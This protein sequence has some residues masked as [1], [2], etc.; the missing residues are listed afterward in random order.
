MISVKNLLRVTTIFTA[1]AVVTVSLVT[2]NSSEAKAADG[3]QFDA[4]NII[5]D[6]LFYDGQAMS[7][8]EVQNFLN[9]MVSTCRS[10]YTCLKDYRQD[11]STKLAESG[12]CTQY[13]GRTN[14][15]A[16]DIIYRVG[17]ACGISQKV[18]IVLLQKEQ[19]LITDTWPTS[20]QYRKATGYACPDTAACDATF[21]GFFNQVYMAALQYKR[22]KANPSGY[23]FI[24]G[25][26][27]NI[28]YNPNGAC[29]SS[30]VFI[31]NAATAGLYDYTPYQPNSA[32][33]ANLY[34]TGDGCSAYGNRN[35][36]RIYTDWFGST[37]ASS[38][39]RTV[40][41]GTVYLMGDG[42][43]YPILDQAT[44][45]AYSALGP[46]SYVSQTYL[47][48]YPTGRPANRIIR[49][50]SGS[51][52][53]T[54]AGIK[55]PFYSC[56][57]VVDYGGACATN[58]YI[59]LTGTQISKFY[60]GPP[61][62]PFIST[63]SG[64]RYYI[65]GGQAREI[66]DDASLAAAGLAGSANYLTDSAIVGLSGGYPIIRDSVV[67]FSRSGNGYLLANSRKYSLT[68]ADAF[69]LRISSAA[70]NGRLS[71]SSL[72]FVQ[73]GGAFSGSVSNSQTIYLASDSGLVASSTPSTVSGANP[74]P[75]SGAFLQAVSISATSLSVGSFV[76]SP[77]S[78]TV[79][80]IMQNDIRPIGAWDSLVAL[81]PP[82]Q[83]IRIYTI[84]DSSIAQM[85][86]GFV[87]LTSGQLYRDAANATVYLINGTTSK[88]AFSSFAF[89]AALGSTTFSYTEPDRLAAYPT[90]S[91]LLTYGV[92]CGTNSYVSAGGQLHEVSTS[93]MPLFPFTYVQLDYFSCLQLS[94]GTPATSFIRD[95]SGSLYQLDSGQKRPI[96][97]MSRFAQI[98]NGVGW[99]QVDSQF[100]AMY[101]TGPDA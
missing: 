86:K 27:N 47:D 15:S 39:M 51:M 19:G 95:N 70:S 101:P 71:D 10:G 2:M 43:K 12:K 32:A 72:S 81:T 13:D 91:N 73:D 59:Q 98:S 83:S 44:L 60:P 56:A 93:L 20:D 75:V 24:A 85:Q 36:W 48:S 1:L 38:L 50:S 30:S 54:D 33:L 87:A 11:T 88:I 52:Y 61:A 46:V 42:A 35:F 25:R 34:G 29:G 65:S 92:R 94:V 4:G 28:Q 17:S 58:G 79:Y 74:V 76:K 55:L 96:Y 89:P 78:G 40:A 31:Q 21:N 41:N 62:T 9:Q 14:E 6:A 57:L 45:S 3:S 97:S 8:G 7:A 69:T 18:L 64:Y 5:D 99:L 37:R 90:E 77:S 84:S 100:A 68:G 67:V 23:N 66:L 16:A 53:F 26:A 80:V 82:G 49:D 63:I 22:Y